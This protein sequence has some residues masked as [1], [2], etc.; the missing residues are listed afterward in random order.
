MECA[1]Q[2]HE[3]VVDRLEEIDR[4]EMET[5]EP[6]V[7][8]IDKTGPLNNYADRDHCLQYM[9]AVG[10]IFGELTADHYED[11]VAKDPRID[12]LRARMVVKENESF[13]ADYY[14]EEKRAIPNSIQVFFKDGTHTPRVEVHYP[15]GHRRRREEGI[16]VLQEKFARNIATRFDDASCQAVIQSYEDIVAFDAKPVEDFMGMLM[17]ADADTSTLLA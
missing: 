14:D 7:R 17:K 3:A 12:A 5:Q 10:L 11:S 6:G 9:A 13:T 2:L 4:V 8:I 16:P 15:I 1:L